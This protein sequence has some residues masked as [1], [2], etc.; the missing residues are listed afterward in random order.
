MALMQTK[1]LDLQVARES[2]LVVEDV[3]QTLRDVV[4]WLEEHETPLQVFN[5]PTFALAIDKLTKSEAA[6][7]TSLRKAASGNPLTPD[8]LK[9][10]AKPKSAAADR[11][12][13]LAADLSNKG[14]TRILS[15][16]EALTADARATEDEQLLANPTA[17]PVGRKPK[18]KATT[19]AEVKKA[20]QPSTT[21][22]RKQG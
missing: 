22:K 16:Q 21:K 5:L 1:P 14:K 3:A 9:P 13:A 2:L 19:A 18:K 15:K 10:R 4:A 17:T 8:T 6:I 12:A 7:R 11:A 20:T